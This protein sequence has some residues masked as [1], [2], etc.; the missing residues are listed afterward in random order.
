[1]QFPRISNA[2]IAM[3]SAVRM[4]GGVDIYY[5]CTVLSKLHGNLS[6]YKKLWWYQHFS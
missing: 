5:D 2:V 4:D 1:M 6:S 3:G